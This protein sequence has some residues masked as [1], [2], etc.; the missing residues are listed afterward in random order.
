MPQSNLVMICDLFKIYPFSICINLITHH[1]D[2]KIYEK[3][4]HFVWIFD[5]SLSFHLV[6]IISLIVIM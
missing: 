4:G 2:N 3:F 1:N 5:K 6:G